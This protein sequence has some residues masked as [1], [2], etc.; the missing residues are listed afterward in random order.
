MCQHYNY[1][2]SRCDGGFAEYVAVPVWNLM[3]LPDTVSYEAAALFEPASVALHAVRRL[4]LE[5]VQSV[6]LFGLG[7]IG[8]LIAEWL[9]AL[10]VPKVYATGHRAQHGGLMKSVTCEAY[11]YLQ[12]GQSCAPGQPECGCRTDVVSQPDSS[13]G[14][15]DAGQSPASS[16]DWILQQTGGLGADVVIDCVAT[17]SSLADA[18][19]AVCP[20][21]QILEVGNPKGDMNLSRDI[22]WKLLRKQIRL[23]GT[24]NSSYTREDTDDWHTTLGYCADGRL[25]LE[26]LVT[27]RLPFDE[28]EKGLR[29]MRGR[30]EYHNKVMI[31]R[32]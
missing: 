11:E 18:L 2:G 3:P 10:G 15:D 13:S 20:G 6:A 1:L 19:L 31:V 32:E 4:E 21:G 30:T 24:W 25:K 12:V 17:P 29:M 28:L 22:Y 14:T 26:E 16:A 5:G 27:H 23:T 9:Y 8:V 7:T